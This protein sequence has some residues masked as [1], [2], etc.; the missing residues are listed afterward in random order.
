ME[1]IYISTHF[2]NFTFN[3]NCY[4]NVLLSYKRCVVL[5]NHPFSPDQQLFYLSNPSCVLGSLQIKKWNFIFYILGHII[6]GI[7]R[8]LHTKCHRKSLVYM[9]KCL[10]IP[11]YTL[12]HLY[13]NVVYSNIIPTQRRTQYHLTIKVFLWQNR[14][15]SNWIIWAW[16]YI[17]TKRL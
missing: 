13:S 9:P 1:H 15:Y 12:K 2:A 11:V 6:S 10:F 5:E 16:I 3:F 4:L 17:W 14:F 8:L 7:W